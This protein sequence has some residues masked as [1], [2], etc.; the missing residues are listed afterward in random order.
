MPRSR[1]RTV[2]LDVELLSADEIGERW[3]IVNTDGVLGGL[4]ISD[5]GYVDPSSVT[6]ALAAGARTRGVTIRRKTAVVGLRQLGEGWLVE[7]DQGEIEADV[8]VNAAGM[9]APRVAAMAGVDFRL[10]RWNTTWS[11]RLMSRRLRRYRRNFR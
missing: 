5:D 2:G 11:S 8:V 3:P 9:W 7:T 1:A 6:L 4:W 10:C